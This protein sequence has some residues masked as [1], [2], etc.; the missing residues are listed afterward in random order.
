MSKQSS[1]WSQKYTTMAGADITAFFD[2]KQSNTLTA[3]SFTVTR[4]KAP[5]YTFGSADLRSV[6]RNKRQGNLLRRNNLVI[7]CIKRSLTSGKA[8]QSPNCMPI[9]RGMSDNHN[10]LYSPAS[11]KISNS[12]G[13]NLF[14]TWTHDR[15]QGYLDICKILGRSINSNTNIIRDPSTGR[16]CKLSVPDEEIVSL[17][18][19]VL[20]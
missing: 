10:R 20:R 19:K 9:L 17:I 5:I 11:T 8:K 7:S 6:S 1:S 4:E 14:A 12:V 18:T 3:I 13:T 15:F 2:E 16:F